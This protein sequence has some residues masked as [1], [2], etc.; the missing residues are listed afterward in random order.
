MRNHTQNNKK[1]VID[2]THNKE[3]IYTCYGRC[4]SYLTMLKVKIYL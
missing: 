4:I 2:I 1:R 3:N